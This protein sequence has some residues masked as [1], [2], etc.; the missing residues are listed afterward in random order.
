MPAYNG[1]VLSARNTE[2]RALQSHFCTQDL[3]YKTQTILRNSQKPIDFETRNPFGKIQKKVY[4]ARLVLAF[5]LIV[6]FALPVYANAGLFSFVAELING[7]NEKTETKQTENVQNMALL[8]AALNPSTNIGG[9]D[10]T[11][12][13]G[14][15]LLS[16]SGPNSTFST[17]HN[18]ETDQ[19]S[20]YVVRDG[21]TVSGIAQMF[22]VSVNTIL[23]GNDL[24]GSGLKIGQ[25]LVILPISGVKHTVKKGD[26]LESIAKNYR[27][28]IREISDYNN[29]QSS[30]HLAIGSEILIPDGEAKPSKDSSSKVIHIKGSTSEA[31]G[32][33]IKPM[34]KYKKTQGIH[35][36]N[37]IDLAAPIGTP[38]F[39]SASGIVAVSRETGWNGGYA[40]YIVIKHGNN[41]QT[42]YAHLDET[43]VSAGEEVIQGQ[44]IGYSGNTGNSTG[45]HLHFE[46]RGAVNP[47]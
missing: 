39:A 5:T 12:I 36:Y 42:L 33:Y 46:I 41:S 7:R 2:Y 27:A 8:S 22:N 40:K 32:Y 15:S 1:Q 30:N 43:I 21:D 20:I 6:S 28:D 31:L 47:F 25:T 9:G 14:N 24:S 16:E 11:V 38:V 10:I 44:I 29:L 34:A 35:G 45:P 4:M 23:W 19:I 13:D 17:N 37:A 3:Q 18:V 26:T